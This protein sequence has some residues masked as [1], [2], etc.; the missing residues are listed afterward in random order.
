MSEDRES[1]VEDSGRK[2]VKFFVKLDVHG[3]G[4]PHNSCAHS[5]EK[6]V[7]SLELKGVELRQLVA[8]HSQNVEQVPQD[9]HD[10]PKVN[11]LQLLLHRQRIPRTH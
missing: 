11:Q 6:F 5:E 9:Y 8:A 4:K 10:R 2:I 3:E 1:S 7:E